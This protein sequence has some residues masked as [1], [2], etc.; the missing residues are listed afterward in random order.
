MLDLADPYANQR[1]VAAPVLRK[2]AELIRKEGWTRS[3]LRDSQGKMCALGAV[4]EAQKAQKGENW[5]PGSVI[6][7]LRQFAQ[8]LF[9]EGHIGGE[10]STRHSIW[11]PG[12]CWCG[13]CVSDAIVR[14]NDDVS[15]TAD[16]VAN[17]LEKA[18]ISC[19]G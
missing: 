6:V 3:V 19:E 1:Q 18:A 15:R 10:L 17:A 13:P 2:A 16:E 11:V 5:H 8:W 7:A 12:N 4:G 9:T 14:W